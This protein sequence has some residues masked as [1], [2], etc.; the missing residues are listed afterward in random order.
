MAGRENRPACC[1]NRVETEGE[2]S[3]DLQSREHIAAGRT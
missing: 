1:D 2:V 3:A